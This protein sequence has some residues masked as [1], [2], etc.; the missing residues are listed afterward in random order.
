MNQLDEAALNERSDGSG[1]IGTVSVYTR[2]KSSC[3][4]RDRPDWARCNCA[5]WFY[6]YRNGK[7]RQI[8][9]KTR[10]WERAEQKAPEI[11]DSFDPVTILQRRLQ[12]KINGETSE[13]EVDIAVEQFLAE[14]VRL[15]RAEATC[16]KY[17]LTLG[18]LSKW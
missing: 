17:K 13:V 3:P 11:R 14:V 10:S 16:G 12:E 5:K 1:A 6:V 2:H 18:R 15:N 7:S 8:S 9:A 4:K